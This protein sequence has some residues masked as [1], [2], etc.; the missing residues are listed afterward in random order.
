[1]YKYDIQF[2][3]VSFVTNKPLCWRILIGGQAR[4]VLHR[5]GNRKFLYLLLNSALNLKLFLE[6]NLKLK[7]KNTTMVNSLLGS[8]AIKREK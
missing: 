1:M 4:H 7:N 8:I 3:N 6:K 5:E 2:I